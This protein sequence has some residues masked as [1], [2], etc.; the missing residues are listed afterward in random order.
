MGTVLPMSFEC[1]PGAAE[2]GKRKKTD[3][4]QSIS[5][6]AENG[7]KKSLL[8]KDAKVLAVKIKSFLLLDGAFNATRGRIE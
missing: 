3:R 6:C 8:H 2:D 7:D 5:S 1:D 4:M